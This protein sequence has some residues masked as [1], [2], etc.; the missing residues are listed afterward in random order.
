MDN[1][2]AIPDNT[3][4]L[5]AGAGLPA[6]L[7]PSFLARVSLFI[8]LFFAVFGTSPPFRP[9]ISEAEAVGSSNLVNQVVLPFLYLL[10]AVGLIAGRRRVFRFIQK[11]KFLTLFLAWSFLSILWSDFPFVSFKRWLRTAGAAAIFLSALISFHTTE[12]WFKYI[13][14]IFAVYLPVSL[15]SIAFVPEAIQWEFPAWRGLATH[16]NMLGQISLV[17]LLVWTFA[18]SRHQGAGRHSAVLFWFM[19]GVL[20]LGSRSVTAIFSGFILGCLAFVGRINRTVLYPMIGRF[21]T[22][23]L[24]TSFVIGF[25]AV[26]Y[27][28]GES[29]VNLLSDLFMIVGK[30]VTFT[31]RSELWVSIFSIAREHL[32]IGCGFAGFWG[33]PHPMLF[34]LFDQYTWLPN[35]AHMGYLE[36]LN[37]TGLIG[38]CLFIGMVV[39][40]FRTLF[41]VYPHHYSRWFI[42]LAL[43]INITES[44]LFRLN[45]LTGL[46]FTLGYIAFFV[47]ADRQHR[48]EAS[49]SRAGGE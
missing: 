1:H 10:S 22:A 8:Y 18:L 31:G 37:E 42:L 48:R 24:M 15:L 38:L 27:I 17:S 12:E 5:Q 13:R 45:L 36:I 47:D 20:L 41:R 6:F 46:M 19:S 40:Y 32:L 34:S 2:D 9:E 14:L 29:I 30:D 16:K 11:E 43:I 49:V 25:F 35:E 26:F 28:A 4:D 39:H 44:T 7:H 21:F 33:V 3:A 23:F